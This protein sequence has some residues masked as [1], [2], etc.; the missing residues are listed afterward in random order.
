M[1]LSILN[2]YEELIWSHFFFSVHTCIIARVAITKYHRLD[3]LNTSNLFFT[4]LA[5]RHPQSMCRQVGFFSGLFLGLQIA[6]FSLCPCMVLPL[7][8]HIPD[9]YLC[10]Q[11]S[12]SCKDTNQ[13]ALGPISLT[14]FNFNYSLKCPNI[15]YNHI[16][17]HWGLEL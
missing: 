14:S 8:I 2:R 13:I 1:C 16:L 15:L 12:S 9:V 5:I 17:R 3:H 11:V 4:V 10:V 7:C 6:T